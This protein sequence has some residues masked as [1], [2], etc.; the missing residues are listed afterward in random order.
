QAK[1]LFKTFTTTLLQGIGDAI[2]DGARV[3]NMSLGVLSNQ[4]GQEDFKRFQNDL[5][6][7]VDENPEVFFVVAAGNEGEILDGEKKMSLPYYIPRKN[8]ICLG[9]LDERVNPTEF[10]NIILKDDI[11][12]VFAWGDEVLSTIPSNF[13]PEDFPLMD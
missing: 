5:I 6:A 10:S 2:Q 1:L 13:C 3:L 7:I 12:M 9:A 4:V 8:V 11:S